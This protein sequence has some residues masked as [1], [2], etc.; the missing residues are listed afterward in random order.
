MKLDRFKAM[1]FTK[2]HIVYDY[3]KF[4]LVKEVKMSK[5]KIWETQDEA[6]VAAKKLN[7]LENRLE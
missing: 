5:Y 6:E 1:S 3:E 7:A 4:D 2:S